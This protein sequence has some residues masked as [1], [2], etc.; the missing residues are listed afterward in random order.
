MPR[1]RV[2][3]HPARIPTGRFV[4]HS[5]G[6]DCLDSVSASF[7]HT[8]THTAAGYSPA[9]YSPRVP[10]SPTYSFVAL[11]NTPKAG[12]WGAPTEATAVYAPAYPES[13]FPPQQTYPHPE[14]FQPGF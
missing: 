4:S 7:T 6:E 8:H 1:S 13:P 12:T 5:L 11:T 2:H 3:P 14:L 10:E 9:G